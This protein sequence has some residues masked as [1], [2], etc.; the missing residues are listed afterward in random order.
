MI[1]P[2]IVDLSDFGAKQL[3]WKQILDESQI[4][5]KLAFCEPWQDMF[6]FTIQSF[7]RLISQSNIHRGV[8]YSHLYMKPFL[9]PR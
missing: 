5:T 6:I 7:R 2:A 9:T 1:V 3:F 8:W 4:L